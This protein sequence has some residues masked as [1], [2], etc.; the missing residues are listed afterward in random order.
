MVSAKLRDSG[1]P[2][3]PAPVEVAEAMEIQ[4]ALSLAAEHIWRRVVVEGS[5]LGV[6]LILKARKV[7]TIEMGGRG[8]YHGGGEV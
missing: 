4:W 2:S 6:I 7:V 5:N 1:S 3:C 8:N